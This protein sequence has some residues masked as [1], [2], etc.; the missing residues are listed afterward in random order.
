VAVPPPAGVVS[1]SV[2]A[3]SS[4][5]VFPYSVVPGGVDSVDELRKAI[6]TD[7]VVADHYKGFD[8]SK[9][10]VERL[11]TP[12]VAHVSYRIGEHVYW[13][14]KSM[15]LPAGE[16]VITDGSRV[17]R[18][19]CANQVADLPGATSPAEPAAGVLD[20]PSHSRP[21]SAFFVSGLSTPLPVSGSM[22]MAGA[23][24]GGAGGTGG[25]GGNS[26]SAGGGG[27]VGG[28]GGGTPSAGTVA[29]VSIACAAGEADCT[30]G[31][32][33]SNP[34]NGPPPGPGD[35]P[36]GPPNPPGG[37]P[38]GGNPPG[39]NPPGGNPPGGFPPGGFPPGGN[40]PGGNPETPWTPPDNPFVPP[41]DTPP[42]GDDPAPPRP[43]VPQTIPEPGSMVL[44]LTGAG[45]LLA[46][47]LS[48]RRRG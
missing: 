15:V 12:R 43:E 20:T 8:L 2:P 34:P 41:L 4:R 35:P 10:R 16:Q 25:G 32:A 37:N 3:A 42:G 31:D 18:I 7:A 13:T 33:G 19:R 47:R 23:S 11:N 28:G 1:A 36:H 22:P 17:A 24:A 29:D 14:R 9:A 30:P 45:G 27:F 26:G 38:P 44:M 5:A 46:R 21:L 39:G 48:A 6:A 40:P